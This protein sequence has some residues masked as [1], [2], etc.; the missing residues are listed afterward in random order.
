[1]PNAAPAA[2]TAEGRPRNAS[3]AASGSTSS[4]AIGTV[5]ER[6]ASSA[7]GFDLCVAGSSI[8]TLSLGGAEQGC[9][10]FDHDRAVWHRHR[11]T[12]S[13]P[14]ATAANQG[15]RDRTV[16][17]RAPVSRRHMAYHGHWNWLGRVGD[18]LRPFFQYRLRIDREQAD[19][20]LAIALHHGR[21]SERTLSDE[22]LFR[23][24]YGPTQ[25]CVVR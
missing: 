23:F 19:H 2:C 14:R 10:D 7:N 1:M 16:E 12:C 3:F 18:D 15:K 9:N 6:R 13:D 5:R 11:K 8:E 21:A 25:P 22:V 24:A 20:L 17:C 4:A